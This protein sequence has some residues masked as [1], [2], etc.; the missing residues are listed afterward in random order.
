[1]SLWTRLRDAL[2]APEPPKGPPQL[3]AYFAGAA[4]NRLTGDFLG[5][6]TSGREEL[7]ADLVTLRTRSRQLCRDNPN[8]RRF[9]ALCAENVIGHKGIRLQAK[10]ENARGELSTDLNGKIESAWDLWGRAKYCTVT[11]QASWP[12]FQAQLLKTVARDGEAFVRLVR[13]YPN[14]FGFALQLLDADLLEV[15]YEVKAKPGQ[16]AIRSSIE[17]DAY[18]RPVAYH[19]LTRHPSDTSAALAGPKARTRIPAGEMLHLFLPNRMGQVRGEPWLTPVIIWL[20]MLYGYAEA[21]LVAARTA[22]AKMGFITQG[23]DAMGADPDAVPQT[24]EAAAGVI[25]RLAKGESFV[26]WDPTHPAGNFGPFLTTVLHQVATG[27]NVSHASLTGD[28]SQVNYSSIRAGMLAERDQWRLLQAWFSEHAC[29]PVYE[30]WLPMAMLSPVLTLP[31]GDPAR[32]VDA[33]TWQPRGWAWVDPAK[34]AE[35]AKQEIA[36]GVSTL[37][38]VCADQGKDLYEVLQ[39]RKAELDLIKEMGVPI[40]PDAPE[41]I[42]T[43][44]TMNDTTTNGDTATTPTDQAKGGEVAR[45]RV[46]RARR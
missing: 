32:Y 9:L 16:N 46:M 18:D 21:E 26:P 2:R 38:E 6:L 30:A 44:T 10:A 34:D 40:L 33:A 45:L 8:A 15:D 29:Q 19:V 25:D 14:R 23:E 24:M 41:L 4:E 3:R 11:G 13:G 12:Y 1:M 28:L 39:Q 42:Q 27:L 7:K 17:V 43:S 37:T 22:A 31:G 20:Q 5:G 35:A 36:I